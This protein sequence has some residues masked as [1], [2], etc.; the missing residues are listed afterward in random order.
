MAAD[1]A[2]YGDNI[3]TFA[4]QPTPTDFVAVKDDKI[5]FRWRCVKTGA[6]VRGRVVPLEGQGPAAGLY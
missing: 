2:F 6:A 5:V 1:F 4:E 3:L